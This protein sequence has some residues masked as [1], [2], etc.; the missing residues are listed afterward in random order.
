MEDERINVL[1]EPEEER[2]SLR[3][4]NTLNRCHSPVKVRGKRGSQF[5]YFFLVGGCKHW[6]KLKVLCRSRLEKFLDGYLWHF[7]RP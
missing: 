2:R 4:R 5:I 7:R 1:T 3:R 6:A